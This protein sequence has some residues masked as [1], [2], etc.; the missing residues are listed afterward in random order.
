M[1][2]CDMI[3]FQEESCGNLIKMESLPFVKTEGEGGTFE[4]AVQMSEKICWK[5]NAPIT[6]ILANIVY[7][8][9]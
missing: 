4:R 7:I 8:M 1:V 2:K 6:S 5:R 3:F 9:L